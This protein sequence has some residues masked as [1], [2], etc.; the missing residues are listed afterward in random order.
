[1]Y[2][3]VVVVYVLVCAFWT[4][5]AKQPSHS[6]RTAVRPDCNYRGYRHR[7]HNLRLNYLYKNDDFASISYP[8]SSS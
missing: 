2:M 7:P 4:Q 3:F 5:N 6:V 8:Y 1:M